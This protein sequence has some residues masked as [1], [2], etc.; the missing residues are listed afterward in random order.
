MKTLNI[1]LVGASRVATYA[2]IAPARSVEGV[3]IAAVS[4]RTAERAQEYADEHGIGRAY[5]DYSVLLADPRIDLIYLGTPPSVHAEQALA[6][7]A[8]GKAVLVEKPFAMNSVEAKQVQAAAKAAGVPLFEAM[9]SPHHALFARILSVLESGEIGRILSIK[10]LFAAPIP[11]TDPLRWNAALGGGALM[12]LGVYPLAWV[13]RIA[14]EEF[15]VNRVEVDFRHGVDASFTASLEFPD[16]VVA[17]VSASMKADAPTA[18]LDI[19]GEAGS[20]HVVNPLAPQRGHSLTVTTA[21]DTRTETVEG[22]STYEV[23]L[24]TIRAALLEGAQY[25][26]PDDDYIR[27]MEAIE[28][29]RAK[30]Q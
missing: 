29:V 23:Q 13:R 17:Q 15:T 30:F 27:S 25:P 8:A 11:E 9:H 28:R 19:E 16:G 4:A 14:G 7:I 3:T 2:M 10:A 5:G 6:A 1:G 21:A 20:L 26:F 24:A 12:D 18:R 22:P